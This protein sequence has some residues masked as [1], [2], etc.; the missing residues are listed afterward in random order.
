M[1]RRMGLTDRVE[2]RRRLRYTATLLALVVVVGLLAVLVPW[3][4]AEAETMTV[5]FDP[6]PAQLQ[7]PFGGQYPAGV[8][9][10]GSDEWWLSAPWEQFTTNSIGFNGRG[11]TTGSFTLLDTWSLASVDVDNEY[12]QTTLTIRCTGQPDK[13]VTLAAHVKT[14]VQTGWTA[15]CSPVTILNTN[16]W[17]TNFD[18]FVLAR[19]DAGGATATAT[20]T[21]EP[22]VPTDTPAPTATITATPT[23]TPTPPPAGVPMAINMGQRFQT[24]DGF[25]VNVNPLNWE[26]AELQPGLDLL[27]EMGAR[28]FRVD[29]TTF[30][31]WEDEN[32]NAD[33][34]VMDT[35]YYSSV[36]EQP[37]AHELWDTIAYLNG[38]GAT[39]VLAPS[40][41]A[42]EWMGGHSVSPGMEAE[43]AETI[44]S[45][46]RYGMVER[47]LTVHYL[48]PMNETNTCTNEG[49]CASATRHAELVR[50]IAERLDAEGLTSVRLLGPETA[51]VDVTYADALCADPLI[52]SKLDHLT[53]HRYDGAP[54]SG[55]ACG[56][57]FWV[58]E[59]SQSQ[60]DGFLDDG[61]QVADE[62]S[63]ARTMTAN[64]LL[65]LS[66]GVESA[67]AWDA[68]DNVHLHAG[69]G[70]I[71][72][73]GLLAYT[74]ACPNPLSCEGSYAPKKRY[75]TN[76][77][78]F[79]F[80]PAGAERVG[81][82]ESDAQLQAVA[83]DVAGE[84]VIVGQNTG[85]A[86]NVTITVNGGSAPPLLR[87][88]ETTAT[89]NMARRADVAA[90]DSTY[91]VPVA[92][93]GFF[94]LVP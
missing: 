34:A 86:R 77:Q 56:K 45:L 25:G 31:N 87:L 70:Q 13:V 80:V 2:A 40:G 18:N 36:Y 92:S 49:V 73:W 16:G 27:W 71:T 89:E 47:G 38:K 94:T 26:D 44:V 61:H 90:S 58:S 76:R 22:G 67:Q 60:T 7:R 55:A 28:I 93:D 37:W 81:V 21:L 75:W 57:S 17:D 64:L 6:A 1:K 52:E 12:R 48:S 39:V 65:H 62:W 41:I 15:P 29:P 84:L 32:D 51:G 72:R 23:P 66:F 46:L 14:T 11:R 42:P 82:A 54:S 53:Y 9:D 24:I 20:Q 83:F 4:Q 3:R 50:A 91:T 8:I 68:F 19:D 78:V 43:F 63:F 5:T 59:W 79:E 85:P 74:G 88:Y 35:T 69:N 30:S 33:P 10:W